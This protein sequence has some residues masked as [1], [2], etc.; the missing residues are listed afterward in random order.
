MQSIVSRFLLIIIATTYTVSGFADEKKPLSLVSF[1]IP[2]FSESLQKGAFIELIATIEQHL[3]TPININ[4]LPAKR[5]QRTFENNDADIYFPGLTSSLQG[6]HISSEPVFYKEVFAFTRTGDIIPRTKEQLIDKKIGLTTG[7]NYGES[8][9]LA[10]LDTRYAQSDQINFLKLQASRT[11]VFLVERY[12]GLKALALSGATGISYDEQYPLDSAPVFFIF[13]DTPHGRYLCAAF[14]QIIK[15]LK[16]SG[17]LSQILQ[18][19]SYP[20]PKTLD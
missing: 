17:Q 7:Y 15:K 2:F 1:S 14:N 16:A 12:S 19:P 18:S 3:D 4:L 13:Q 9:N 20:S 11:D 10:S 8:L 6:H 5:A